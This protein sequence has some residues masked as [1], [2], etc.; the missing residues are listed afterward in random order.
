VQV[1]LRV[2]DVV[3]LQIQDDGCGFDAAEFLRS[4]PQGHG[5]GVFGMRERVA[6]YGGQFVIESGEG[7]GTQVRLSIPLGGET[8]ESEE[9]DGEDPRLAH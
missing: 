2:E 8:D 3:T 7:T 4:P 9:D 1:S 6:G 5:M